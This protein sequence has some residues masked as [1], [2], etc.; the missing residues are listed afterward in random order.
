MISSLYQ[1]TIETIEDHNHD[2]PHLTILLYWKIGKLLSKEEHLL[3]WDKKQVL[4]ALRKLAAQLAADRIM[5]CKLGQLSQMRKLYL[6][7]PDLKMIHPTL[8]WSHFLLLVQIPT[9]AKRWF[10]LHGAKE[11]HWSAQQL[12]REIALDTFS[13]IIEN[14]FL[15]SP[16]LPAIPPGPVHVLKEPYIFEFLDIG[17]GQPLQEK[18]LLD[19]MLANL[20]YLLQELGDG[21]TFIAHQKLIA[22]PSGKQFFIDL[23]FYHYHLKCFVL[24]DLKTSE[25]T[26]GDIGQMDMYIR[27]YEDFWRK[28]SDNPTI[29]LILCP[30]K[31]PALVDYSL[32]STND[33]L[34]ALTYNLGIGN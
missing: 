33:Q 10:Y 9:P 30:Q 31:D 23:V 2:T 20:T 22:T 14:P 6:A 8:S 26:H 13:R 15:R 28:P 24:V 29:G 25:L 34:F 11:N 4:A 16:D 17:G 18:Y 5:E 12:K 7:F 1:K 27:L 3:K 32:L 21:F 19:A